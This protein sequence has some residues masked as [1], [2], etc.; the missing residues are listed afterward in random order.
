MATNQESKLRVV[1]DLAIKSLWGDAL[2]DYSYQPSV[3]ASGGLV[4]VWDTSYVIVWSSMSYEHVLV[5]KGMVISS[6]EDFVII[7]V[8]VPCETMTKRELWY[9][10]SSIIVNYMDVSLCVCGNFNAV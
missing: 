2:C 8:Y 6:A 9:R 7:N 1:D 3:G 5:I 4:T 10:L